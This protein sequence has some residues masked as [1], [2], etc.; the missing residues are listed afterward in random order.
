MA[1]GTPLTEVPFEIELKFYS[2]F[3]VGTRLPQ[4]R[5]GGASAN[6]QIF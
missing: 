4:R 6:F 5:C 3:E 1:G 2:I